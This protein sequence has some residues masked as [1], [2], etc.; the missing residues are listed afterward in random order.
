[1]RG[2]KE[3]LRDRSLSA[4]TDQV[5]VSRRSP[6]TPSPAARSDDQPEETP[7]IVVVTPGGGSPP[8][9][10]NVSSRNSIYLPRFVH[11]KKSDPRQIDGSLAVG[12]ANLPPDPRPGGNQAC[13]ATGAG[14]RQY[15]ADDSRRRK[16][17]VGTSHARMV[18]IALAPPSTLLTQVTVEQRLHTVNGTRTTPHRY[19]L[20]AGQ[21]RAAPT[22]EVTRATR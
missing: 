18:A 15:F 14:R 7:S 13:H 9:R 10:C 21:A 4:W 8:S 16:G 12:R 2:T 11:V 6:A 5:R 19:V 22:T 3:V 17:L 1:M 20:I